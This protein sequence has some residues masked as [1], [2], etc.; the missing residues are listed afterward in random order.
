MYSIGCSGCRKGRHFYNASAS[1]TSRY[2]DC[3]SSD[4]D[5]PITSPDQCWEDAYCPFDDQYG[6]GSSIAGPVTNDVVAFPNNSYVVS[7]LSSNFGSILSSTGEPLEPTGVDGII[8]ACAG[9]VQ[10]VCV[11]CVTRAH[12]HASPT[13]ASR[14]GAARA[15][16]RRLQASTTCTGA[17][18]CA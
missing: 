8:G 6:G 3:E 18:P 14:R 7:G 10:G 1:K 15:C 12:T 13:V 11:S 17:F 5:C 16:S 2:V 9:R 4:V